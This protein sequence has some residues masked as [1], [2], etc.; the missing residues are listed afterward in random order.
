MVEKIIVSEL[1]NTW[2]CAW[3]DSDG[4][5]HYGFGDCPIS[6][7][8]RLWLNC[9]S[10]DAVRLLLDAGNATIVKSQRGAYGGEARTAEVD[11]AKLEAAC[12]RYWN[13]LNAMGQQQGRAGCH[14]CGQRATSVGFFNELVCGECGG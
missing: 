5:K 3:L 6:E 8:A 11:V 12:D 4:A 13:R 9:A 10:G 14:Y 7:R 2:G 1:S